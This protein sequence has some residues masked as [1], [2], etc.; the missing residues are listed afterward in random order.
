M[1]RPRRIDAPGYP[2]HVVQS[3]NNRQAVFFSSTDP[4]LYLG[5][6]RSCANEHRCRIH[7]YVL[8]GNQVHLLV[9]PDVS[10]WLSAMTPA[11]NR[12]YVRR[13]KDRQP[14]VM[15]ISFHACRYGSSSARLPALH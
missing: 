13:V 6:I 2:Q 10:G 1:P 7:T 8:M 9:T 5:L 14:V 15:A 3:G 11:V 4:A 12:P